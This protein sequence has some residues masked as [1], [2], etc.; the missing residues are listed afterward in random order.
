MESFIKSKQVD[1]THKLENIVCLW[2]KITEKDEVII[3][4]H[5]SRNWP[6]VANDIFLILKEFNKRKYLKKV[7]GIY[8]PYVPLLRTLNYWLSWLDEQDITYILKNIKFIEW[9]LFDENFKL[10]KDICFKLS[11]ELTIEFNVLIELFFNPLI[12]YIKRQDFLI[13]EENFINLL[14]DQLDDHIIDWKIKF[15]TW[16]N[17][18]WE[19][20]INHFIGQFWLPQFELI[21]AEDLYKKHSTC[22]WERKNWTFT[23]TKL[24]E[25]NI[26]LLE[27][28]KK[29][30]RNH[31][32]RHK[33]ITKETISR[34]FMILLSKC[35]SDS[36]FS[37]LN[38]S[39][40]IFK[41]RFNT[42]TWI[43]EFE[44]MEEIYN[45]IDEHII[46]ILFFSNIQWYEK[47]KKDIH[48]V[49]ESTV[50]EVLY[51]I[52]WESMIDLI[53]EYANKNNLSIVLQRFLRDWTRAYA[54]YD[55]NLKKY[56]QIPTDF[57]T[58][59]IW[60]SNEFE[61]FDKNL[62]LSLSYLKS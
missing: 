11:N 60:N 22:I 21:E 42:K 28:T 39:S 26:T 37:Q 52:S 47:S 27:N 3:H 10:N 58:V 1:Q 38:N 25:R 19:N 29:Q 4:L 13:C 12:K 16:L 14:Y 35:W 15:S 9:N 57:S 18:L 53:F 23:T 49:T 5:A 51:C 44:T 62:V 43:Y 24:Y 20:L 33:L 30:I 50:E 41:K 32:K 7:I 61:M 31:F 54:K 2:E 36:Y 46:N 55:A 40:N 45:L 48:S 56:N 59:N 8:Q 17:K 34:W 6:P